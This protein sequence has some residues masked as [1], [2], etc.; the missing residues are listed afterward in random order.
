MIAAMPWIRRKLR[1][2]SAGNRSTRLKNGSAERSTGIL[3]IPNGCRAAPRNQR[4]F[5]KTIM[6]IVYDFFEKIEIPDQVRDDIMFGNMT[7]LLIATG[8]RGKFTEIMEVLH[9][10]K[11]FE[12]I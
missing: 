11:N 12:F 9:D 8:N 3:K 1:P 6:E 10:L 4:N 5:A 2:N 7:K